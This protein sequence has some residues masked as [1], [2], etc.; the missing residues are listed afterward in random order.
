MI[1]AI[2]YGHIIWVISYGP[3]DIGYLEDSR[4]DVPGHVV[5][6]LLR[7]LEDDLEED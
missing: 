6:F 7:I 5:Q 4:P 3:Y 2:S 1:R